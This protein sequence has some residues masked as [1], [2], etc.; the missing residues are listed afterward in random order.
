MVLEVSHPFHTCRLRKSTYYQFHQM[1]IMM[2]YIEDESDS[3]CV[4]L[5]VDE[6]NELDYDR[7]QSLDKENMNSFKI[8]KNRGHHITGFQV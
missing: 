6:V 7:I 3:E 2:N 4:E 8:C 1:K 5:G